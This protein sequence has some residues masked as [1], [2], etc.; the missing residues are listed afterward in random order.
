MNKQSNAK[1]KKSRQTANKPQI[2][3]VFTVICRT[4]LKVECV[5]EYKF[6]PT[7]K[8]RFDYAIPE[9]KIA[10]EVEGGIWTGGRHTRAQGFLGDI[11]KYNTATLM[12][13]RVFR[14]TPDELYRTATINLIKNAILGCF[15]PGNPLFLP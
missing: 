5:K 9:H 15:N 13:W 6:H 4:D 8:W 1:V 2:R 14:T 12:G 7:R 11:E 3:D 10:L